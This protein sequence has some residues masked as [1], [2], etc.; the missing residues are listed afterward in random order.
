MMKFLDFDAFLDS[1]G[2]GFIG[3]MAAIILFVALIFVIIKVGPIY[4]TNFIF[5]EDVK[6]AV[7]RASAL[8][9]SNEAIVKDILELAKKNHINITSKTAKKDISIERYAGQIHVEVRYFV[10]V[11]FLIMK[12][13]LKFEVKTSSFITT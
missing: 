6:T 2:K 4:Y 10:P 11:D 12:K 7:S 9:L 1:E 5:D 13:T 8:S 3:C